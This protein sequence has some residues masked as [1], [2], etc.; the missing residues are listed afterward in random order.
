MKPLLIVVLLAQAATLEMQY[1]SPKPQPTDCTRRTSREHLIKV[2]RELDEVALPPEYQAF[3]IGDGLRIQSRAAE[4]REEA[5]RLERKEK[6]ITE[7][8]ATLACLEAQ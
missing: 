7:F 6:A 4:L 1:V 2:L 8:R 3:T 5:D